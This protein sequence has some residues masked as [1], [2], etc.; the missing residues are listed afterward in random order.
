MWPTTPAGRM[1]VA[2]WLPV[3]W[4]VVLG[5]C[6]A[7]P[8]PAVRRTAPPVATMTPVSLPTLVPHYVRR[9][10]ATGA[11]SP[12]DLTLDELG[13]VVVAD[14]RTGCVYR[15]GP[16]GHLTA[17]LSGL[18]VP[19]GVAF[20]PDGSLLIGEQGLPG[21]GM[22]QIV[23]WKPGGTQATHFATFANH[24]P[25]AG[26]DGIS[27]RPDTGD[28]LVADSPNGTVYDLSP[29]GTRRTVVATHLVRPVDAIANAR[30]TVFIADEFGGTVVAVT[31]DGTARVLAHLS[32]P[33]DLAIDRNGTLLV[34]VLGNNT[35]VR[36]DPATGRVLETVATDLL[37][38]QGLA[39]DGSGNIYLSEERGNVILE[40]AVN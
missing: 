38:P 16:D 6:E 25:T 21:A 17:L 18:S 28:V 10:I 4:L 8:Q 14:T 29:D 1:T 9:V 5:G 3:V 31:P 22:D 2:R 15:V 35:L 33:D 12:D 20:M 13:T 39:V 26:V 23:R 24:T 7:M 36:L 30:G 34:T 40:L 37:E 27:I 19:E 32:Y 11:G